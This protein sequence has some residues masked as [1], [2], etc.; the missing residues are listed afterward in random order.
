MPSGRGWTPLREQS[1]FRDSALSQWLTCRSGW[2]A[3]A[4]RRHTGRVFGTGTAEGLGP[5][6][7]QHPWG[8]KRPSVQDT[9]GLNPTLPQLPPPWPIPYCSKSVPPPPLSSWNRGREPNWCL[10][11]V[12]PSLLSASPTTTTLSPAPVLHPTLL[13]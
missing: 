11:G 9:D 5:P 2:V 8:R 7:A 1:C 12:W 3:P 10:R 4:Q 6:W 13:P